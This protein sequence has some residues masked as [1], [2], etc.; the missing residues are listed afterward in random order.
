MDQEVEQE[1]NISNSLPKDKS[2]D[3]TPGVE[4]ENV[5]TTVPDFVE[6]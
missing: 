6:T 2:E 3:T 1:I 5:Q 4:S